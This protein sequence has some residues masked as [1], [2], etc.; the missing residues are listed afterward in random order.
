L[1]LLFFSLAQT[2]LPNYV[3]LLLPALAIMVGSWFAGVSRGADRRPALISAAVVP[4]TIG[5]IAFAIVAFGR[6]NQLAIEAV[7]PQLVI[8]AIGMLAGSL[9]VL[10]SLARPALRAAAPYALALTSLVLVLFIVFVGEPVAERLK[11]IAPMA[12]II[13]AQRAPGDVVAIR[14]VS[15]GNG[16]VFYTAP[17]VRSIDPDDDRSFLRAVCAGEA[18]FVVTRLADV[19][20]L[21]ALAERVN[22]KVTSL[23]ANGRTVLIRVDG[24]R[25]PA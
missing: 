23:D 12:A 13:N 16:L 14:G 10:I 7:E 18:A 2:K 11:P 9:V 24:G 15:G 5:C 4:L 3:A 1:P 25:C 17:G 6:S 22:R 19:P 20:A 21:E 8:L